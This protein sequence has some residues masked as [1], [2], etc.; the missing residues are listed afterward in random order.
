MGTQSATQRPQSQVHRTGVQEEKAWAIR[1]FERLGF[2]CGV[3]Q[4]KAGENFLS[5]KSL[6]NVQDTQEVRANHLK[7]E[8][9]QGL[10]RLVAKPVLQ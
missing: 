10:R 7:R 9:H 2:A 3:W 6:F 1:P 8:S 5:R 4:E